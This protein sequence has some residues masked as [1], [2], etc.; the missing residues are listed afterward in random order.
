M[1]GRELKIKISQRDSFLE[2][3][4]QNIFSLIKGVSK[5]ILKFIKMSA[6]MQ[7]NHQNQK[8]DKNEAE[9]S[10]FQ[11]DIGNIAML[12]FLYILQGKK[13]C[14]QP[15][16]LNVSEYFSAIPIGISYAIPILLQNRGATYAEQAGFTVA[17]YP[18]TSKS[19]S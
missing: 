1:R 15:H 3:Q 18:F 2:L 5:F 16:C 11:D 14:D 12:L 8:T 17:F 10:D 6:G 13:N 9:K 4:S 19:S 7:Q